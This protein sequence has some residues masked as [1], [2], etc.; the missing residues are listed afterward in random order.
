[1]EINGFRTLAQIAS[2]LGLKYHGAY[3][4]ARRGH[5]GTPERIG[6]VALYRTANIPPAQ[7]RNKAGV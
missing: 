3:S 7:N 2:D 1:M 5:F 6:N 4:R